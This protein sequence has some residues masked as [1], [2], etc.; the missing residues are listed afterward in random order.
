MII[1][2]LVDPWSAFPSCVIVLTILMRTA[3]VGTM[4]GLAFH[5]SGC[6]SGAR[7][8]AMLW[9]NVFS[10]DFVKCLLSFAKYLKTRDNNAVIT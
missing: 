9:I 5:F 7:A 3:V 10:Y 1:R 4:R 6:S 2:V 8:Y